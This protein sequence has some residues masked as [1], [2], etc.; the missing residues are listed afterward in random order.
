MTCV[1]R[2]R[3]A[4]YRRGAT[5]RDNVGG[6]FK[7]F[8][9]VRAHGC[10]AESRG[11]EIVTNNDDS[12][13]VKKNT[14]LH[15]DDDGR[16]RVFDFRVRTRNVQSV[17]KTVCIDSTARNMSDFFGL[18]FA[19]DPND[20]ILY[21]MRASEERKL[22]RKNEPDDLPENTA[23]LNDERGVK[24]FA[25]DFVRVC[26]ASVHTRRTSGSYFKRSGK[27]FS[28]T[29][30][31]RTTSADRGVRT[32][33]QRTTIHDVAVSSASGERRRR[34]AVVNTTTTA[35]IE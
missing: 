34:L 2:S 6:F 26:F 3:I 13:S 12:S 7:I 22:Y 1:C 5:Y 11:H 25:C 15:D 30:P 20:A 29:G 32:R 21:I 4:F 31:A 24:S 18:S 8:M 14:I 23:E 9:Y 35:T 33:N 19:N 17:L 16:Q 27:R 10:A 28:G